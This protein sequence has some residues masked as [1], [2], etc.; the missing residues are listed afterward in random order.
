M[1]TLLAGLLVSALFDLPPAQIRLP[2]FVADHLAESG[3]RHPVTAVLLNFRGYDTFLEVVV[4]LLA[5][6]GVLASGLPKDRS[7]FTGNVLLQ[8]LA[9]HALPLMLLAAVYLLW[10]GAHQP[11]GAFQ[12]AAV[13]AAAAVLFELSGIRTSKRPD[14]RWFRRITSAGVLLFFAVAAAMLGN[15]A[16]LQYPPEQAG[17]FILLIESGLTLSLAVNLAA[18]FLLRSTEPGD[19]QATDNEP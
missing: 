17:F 14:P 4:L 10:A 18:F 2:V 8:A 9:R 13:L 19:A 6:V 7:P 16:L 11:G 3:V 5:L 12:A 1:L 15:G